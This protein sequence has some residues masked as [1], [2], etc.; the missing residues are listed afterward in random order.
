[1][2]ADEEARKEL[3]RS[4]ETILGRH[5]PNPNLHGYPSFDIALLSNDDRRAKF[6][7]FLGDLL[8]EIGSSESTGPFSATDLSA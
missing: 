8:Q 2:L 7:R 4:L 3:L 1:V 6:G 5:S